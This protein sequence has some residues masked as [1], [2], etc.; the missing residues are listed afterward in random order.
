MRGR[1]EIHSE[2]RV[3]S[4]P[5]SDSSPGR[6]ATDPY[7]V[8]KFN[9]GGYQIVMAMCFKDNVGSANYNVAASTGMVGPLMVASWVDDYQITGSTQTF[10]AGTQV[11]LPDGDCDT[12]AISGLESIASQQVYVLPRWSTHHVEDDKSVQ[13]GSFALRNG[14]TA[15]AVVTMLMEGKYLPIYISPFEFPPGQT[16]FTPVPRVVFWFQP[17]LAQSTMITKGQ[18]TTCE[19]DMSATASA[20]ISFD[21]EGK[22]NRK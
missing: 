21:R 7:W 9:D 3:S 12:I 13:K 16:V 11:I 19:V 20:T 8:D 14:V 5:V 6:Q 1:R 17:A 15:S 10:R 18:E 4:L 22:W 2:P